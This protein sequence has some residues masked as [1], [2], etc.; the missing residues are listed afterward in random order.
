M[1]VGLTAKAAALRNVSLPGNPTLEVR[2]TI[3]FFT[4]SPQ[5][6]NANIANFVSVYH[7]KLTIPLNT[8]TI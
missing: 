1:A 5:Y 6:K 3:E 4:N 2:A 7:S 8:N